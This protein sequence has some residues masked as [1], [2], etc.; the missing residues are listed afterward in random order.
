MF[1]ENFSKTCRK[2]CADLR[3]SKMDI[4]RS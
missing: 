2:S 3:R 4:Q 1:R